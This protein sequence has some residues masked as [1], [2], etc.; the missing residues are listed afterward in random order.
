[1]ENVDIAKEQIVV[2]KLQI[3]RIE[4]MVQSGSVPKGDLLELEAQLADEEFQLVQAENQVT[5]SHL[6]LLQLLQLDGDFDLEIIEPVLDT[7][8][9]LME[10]KSASEIFQTS[11][12]VM[13]E[14][15]SAELKLESSIKNLSVVRGMRSP[16]L[17]MGGSIGTGYSEGS[18]HSFSDQLNENIYRNF[19][20]SLNIPIFSK[21]S[22][23]QSVDRARLMKERANYTLMLQKNDLR[24]DVE[25][26][27][28]DAEAAIKS[29]QA[30]KKSLEALQ[31]SFEYA[32]K[33]FNSGL[34]NSVDYNTN[35]NNLRKA[36]SQ[37]IRAKYEYIF[38]RKILDFFQG[39]P[40]KL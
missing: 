9:L 31:L 22:I 4:K 15:K 39:K 3:V 40:I 16:F 8:D 5:L 26:A 19:S 14:I 1:M 28:A 36:E 11:L 35:K 7:N 38:K 30:N 18:D 10:E 33:R 29:F 34:I 23:Q 21:Y 25:K 17:T 27:Y 32:Q 20:L 13:P 37:L 6:N 24:N 12:T 2:T